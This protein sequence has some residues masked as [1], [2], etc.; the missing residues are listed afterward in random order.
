MNNFSLTPVA[1]AR[2]DFSSKF[3][4][5]R[6]SGL[7]SDLV[8]SIEF[9]SDFCAGEFTRG[10]NSFSHVW[11]I[12]GFSKNVGK[13]QPTV[14]PPRLNGNTRVGVFASRS[15]FR[16]NSLGLSSVKLLE[17]TRGKLLVGGADLVD[18]TPIFDIKPYVRTDVHEDANFSYATGADYRMRVDMSEDA[19]GDF[20][21][22]KVS[23]LRGVLAENP[24]PAI[25]DDPNR[26][27]GF[28]FAG[29]EIKFRC[30][31][32]VVHLVET[33]RQVAGEC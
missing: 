22:A 9:T 19:L 1:F 18:G 6:Q 23:A 24:R 8:A 11:L 4:V 21:R 14:R 13:W 16:P 10:L 28:G 26:I 25:H 32:G 27:Y 2:T 17:V 7:V 29:F 30:E 31:D 5:P 12:W 15:P 20:P 3:G 33:Q